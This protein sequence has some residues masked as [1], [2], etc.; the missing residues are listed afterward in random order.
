MLAPDKNGKK[1]YKEYRQAI[2]RHL[3]FP[4]LDI[5]YITS[6]TKLTYLLTS[7]LKAKYAI[8]RYTFYLKLLIE[9]VI[10]K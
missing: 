4:F 2:H 6:I 7:N 8:L 9:S 10:S 1:T 3:S 5:I